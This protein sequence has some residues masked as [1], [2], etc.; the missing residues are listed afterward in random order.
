MGSQSQDVAAYLNSDNVPTPR[1]STGHD[2][3]AV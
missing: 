3:N 1:G 2:I